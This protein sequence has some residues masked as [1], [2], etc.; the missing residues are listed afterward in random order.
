[1]LGTK[2]MRAAASIVYFHHR[3][4]FARGDQ[5]STE[6]RPARIDRFHADRSETDRSVG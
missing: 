6:P 2:F 5:S 1:L 3:G 4:A